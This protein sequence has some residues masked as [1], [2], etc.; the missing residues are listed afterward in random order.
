M[1]VLDLEIGLEHEEV[2]ALEDHQGDLA[3]AEVGPSAAE[4]REAASGPG[5]ALVEVE[6]GRAEGAVLVPQEGPGGLAQPHRE[7]AGRK[8]GGRETGTATEGGSWQ[9][10]GATTEGGG[11]PEAD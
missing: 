6:Q 11:R 1:K 9:E 5:P 10:T 2:P 4:E 3:T 7:G 8:R